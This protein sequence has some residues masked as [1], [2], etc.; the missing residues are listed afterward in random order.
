MSGF[1]GFEVGMKPG[2]ESEMLGLVKEL[3]ELDGYLFIEL[4]SSHSGIAYFE[5]EEQAQTAQWMLMM[6]GS[7]EVEGESEDGD[8]EMVHS[9]EGSG[10]HGMQLRH[11]QGTDEGNG[12]GY[13][14]RESETTAADGSGEQSDGL[15]EE[16]QDDK[17]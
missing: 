10:D 1:F 12:G 16:P 6:N 11:G 5:T 8:G 17:G 2:Y 13:Q 7:E 14:R 9:A 15:A 3:E 4:K